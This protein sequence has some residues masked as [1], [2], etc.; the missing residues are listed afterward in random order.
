[1]PVTAIDA[2][3]AG[4]DADRT[5]HVDQA[6]R[7]RQMPELRVLQHRGASQDG[8]AERAF[9]ARVER[10]AAAGIQLRIEGLQ[11]GEVG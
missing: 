11:D 10:G 3:P 7:Q 6:M 4:L 5:I 9:E 8:A 1:M 2:D